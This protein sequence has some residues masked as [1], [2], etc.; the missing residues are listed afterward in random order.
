MPYYCQNNYFAWFKRWRLTW[1]ID[2]RWWWVTFCMKGPY[3]FQ[4][5]NSSIVMMLTTK[6]VHAGNQPYRLHEIEV[7]SLVWI[8][9]V[10]RLPSTHEL[11]LK[12]QPSSLLL[13]SLRI[14]LWTH[15]RAPSSFV[16]DGWCFQGV[17][18]ENRVCLLCLA[19]CMPSLLGF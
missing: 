4:H 15:V 1:A 3:M 12:L 18:W 6:S 8:E 11:T 14:L 2:S 9:W 13:H 10:A 5:S 19:P 17:D 7:D 16:F